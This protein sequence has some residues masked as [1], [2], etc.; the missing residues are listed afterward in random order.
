[1]MG[2]KK[3]HLPGFMFP[4][5]G[6]TFPT[7]W[8]IPPVIVVAELVFIRP[9]PP[10]AEVSDLALADWLA[11]WFQII[12]TVFNL[13]PGVIARVRLKEGD[14]MMVKIIIRWS[15]LALITGALLMGAAMAMVSLRPP[16]QLPT[17]LASMLLLI[18][19]LLIML[20]RS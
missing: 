9:R 7:A 20:G 15:G 5:I 2:R 1:M 6:N 10:P 16:G 12:G 17:P 14:L 4:K 18:A 11:I 3:R 13:S 8:E 19:S